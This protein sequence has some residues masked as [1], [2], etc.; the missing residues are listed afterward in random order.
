[1][2][3]KRTEKAGCGKS[4]WK[5]QFKKVQGIDAV[6]E[7]LQKDKRLPTFPE[8]F[9]ACLII[10]DAECVNLKTMFPS[11]YKDLSVWL[12]NAGVRTG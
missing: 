7:V 5:A 12:R 11:L 2:N 1:M 9:I 8:L 10:G 6:L 3:K 4:N